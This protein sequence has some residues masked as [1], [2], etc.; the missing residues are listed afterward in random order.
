MSCLVFCGNCNIKKL[1]VTC[2]Q[3]MADSA[4]TVTTLLKQHRQWSKAGRKRDWNEALS[5]KLVRIKPCQPG[6]L[7]NML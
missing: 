4:F 6:R 3:L 1:C 5:L 7:S 2:W